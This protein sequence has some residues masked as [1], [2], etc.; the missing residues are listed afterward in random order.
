M[1]RVINAVHDGTDEYTVTISGRD[2]VVVR[3]IS[4]AISELWDSREKLTLL[5]DMEVVK[6]T[7]DK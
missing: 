4:R 1:T 5:S 2:D 6:G 7:E 3:E